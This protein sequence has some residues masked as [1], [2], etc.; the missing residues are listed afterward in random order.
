VVHGRPQVDAQGVA[1]EGVGVRFTRIAM[2]D[3]QRLEAFLGERKI[4]NQAALSAALVRVRA[5]QMSRRFGSA[6]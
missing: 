5:E 3:E 2:A 4:A 1:R 6:A